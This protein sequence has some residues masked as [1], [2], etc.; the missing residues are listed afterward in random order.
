MSI[1]IKIRLN[2]DNP[3]FSLMQLAVLYVERCSMEE[4]SFTPILFLLFSNLYFNPAI[5]CTAFGSIIISY[6]P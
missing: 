4:I 2:P 1:Y 5:Q 6:R 3:K